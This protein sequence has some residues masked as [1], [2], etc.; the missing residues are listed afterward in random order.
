MYR[1]AWMEGGGQWRRLIDTVQIAELPMRSSSSNALE[2]SFA[3]SDRRRE[4]LIS[5]SW[6]RRGSPRTP[7]GLDL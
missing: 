1:Q 7:V 5:R 3:H 4:G 2:I 6:H